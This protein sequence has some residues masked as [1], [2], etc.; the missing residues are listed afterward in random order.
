MEKYESFDSGEWNK[1]SGI[2]PKE[3]YYAGDPDLTFLILHS[4]A[5]LYPEDHLPEHGSWDI[6]SKTTVSSQDVDRQELA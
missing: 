2:A 5:W 3:M 4:S 6:I 1:T